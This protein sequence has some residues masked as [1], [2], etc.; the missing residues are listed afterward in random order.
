VESVT[1]VGGR[2]RIGLGGAQ[3]LV[4]EVTAESAARLGLA[5]GV[6]VT[7]VFKATATR[8]VER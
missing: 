4:A 5:T 3:S 1:E 7:A 8:L 2:A 6:R